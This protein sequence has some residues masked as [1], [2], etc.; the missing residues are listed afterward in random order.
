MRK[1]ILA[2]FIIIP[3]ISAAFADEAM[4]TAKSKYAE[5]SVTEAISILDSVIAQNPGNTQAK[6]ML[7]D[8]CVDSGEQEYNARNFKNAYDYYKKALKLVPTHAIASELYWKMK[9]E[10]DVDNLKNEGG[11]LP[12]KNTAQIQKGTS[13]GKNE[14]QGGV[15]IS[16]AKKG[17]ETGISVD[18]AYTKKILQMEER[19]NQRMLNMLTQT[20]KLSAK[21]DNAVYSFFKN[22]TYLFFILIVALL[23]VFIAFIYLGLGAIRFA[24][25]KIAARKGKK[26]YDTMF[27]GD[28]STVS[29]NEL[30]KMQNIKDII[31][32]IKNGDLDWIS[33]KKSIT[34]MDKELRIEILN[35]IESKLERE[36]MPLTM[37]QADLLMSLLLDGD[38]YIRKRVNLFLT[39]QM[40]QSP[41]AR[42]ALPYNPSQS[43]A[44]D[45]HGRLLLPDQ[46]TS[47]LMEMS[48]MED[49]NIVIPLSKIV[50]RKVFNDNHATRVGVDSYY[51]AG[52]LGLSTAECNL[53]YIAGLIHDIGY[54]DI[55][56]EILNKRSSLTEKEFEIIK[57]HTQKGLQ[58]LDF[59]ELPQPVREGILYHHEKW[60]GDGY[61]EGIAGSDIPLVARVIAIFDVY[62][63]LVL[64]R[65]QRP[66][67]PVKDAVKIIKKGI[68]TLFD[69]A[70]KQPFEHMIQE[71]MLSKEDPWKKQ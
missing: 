42:P 63:A 16:S 53:Y 11:P 44:T 54:L 25:K 55:P 70:L 13:Q 41:M 39:G 31:N 61:P 40:Q 69:P 30:I 33:V 71:N 8:I 60:N 14:G 65:P 27:S 45:S 17:R 32:K 50:D 29:Y 67:F 68:G 10:F 66:P 36:R 56:S 6:K 15:D 7:A 24:R 2:T 4:Q 59:T 62:E 48:M 37:G 26:E 64:P 34:E 1:I 23:F 58:L 20:Q 5:G 28:A 38:E 18:E 51:M 47:S 35:L 21:S 22:N 57:T 46:T 52:L 19:F 9:K 3:F 43:S 12:A 49:L